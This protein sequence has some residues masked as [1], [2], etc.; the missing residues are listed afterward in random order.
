MTLQNGEVI[1]AGTVVCTVGTSVNPLIKYAELPW[2]ANRI[3]TT[4]DLRVEGYEQV[5]TL[6]NCAAVPNAYDQ[7]VCPPTSQF[8]VRQAKHLARE[9]GECDSRASCHSVLLQT[10][11][12]VCLDWQPQSRRFGFRVKILWSAR[13]AALAIGLLEQNAHRGAVEFKSRS[14]GSGNCSSRVTS[15]S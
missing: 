10:S 7:G 12:R 15:C 2:T 5:W 1:E 8:A 6:G 13:V 4:P 9:P 11:G 3:K 14:I